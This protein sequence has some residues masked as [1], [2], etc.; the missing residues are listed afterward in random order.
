M[1]KKLIVL[2]CLIGFIT[3]IGLSNITKV[4]ASFDEAQYSEAYIPTP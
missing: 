4:D 3:V 1:K 2:V